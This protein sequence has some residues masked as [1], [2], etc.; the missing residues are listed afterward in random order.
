MFEK[1]VLRIFFC[2]GLISIP[3]LLFR[4]PPIKDWIIVF[5]FTGIISG[6]I[7]MVLVSK[8]YLSYPKRLFPKKFQIHFL[9]DYIMCPVVSVAYNQWTYKDKSFRV[10]LKLFPFTIFHMLLEVLAERYTK[11]IRWKKGWKW[12]H[13]YFSMTLKYFIVRISIY[14]IRKVSK[15]QESY[16]SK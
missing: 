9:F 5:L 11:L 8:N 1:I 2:G 3:L 7:D 6:I 14:F 13:T 12:Y 15:Q 4:K 16:S 10:F